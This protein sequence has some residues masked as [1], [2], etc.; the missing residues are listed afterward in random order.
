MANE[1]AKADRDARQR[2][3]GGLLYLA[4]CAVWL[5]GMITVNALQWYHVIPDMR[6]IPRSIGVEANTQPPPDQK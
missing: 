6:E 2:Q 1:T 4:I 3:I 5:I